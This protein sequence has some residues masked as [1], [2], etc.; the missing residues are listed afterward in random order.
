M[1]YLAVGDIHID[2]G[3]RLDDLKKVL[4]QIVSIVA[5]RKVDKVLFLGDMFTSRRPTALEYRTAYE[6]VMALRSAVSKT[7]SRAIVLLKGNHDLQRDAS[8]LD[9]F[10][11][12][13]VP[14][15][16]VVE[17]GHVEDGIFMGHFILKE[18]VMGPSNFQLDGAVTLEQLFTRF[19][20]HRLYLFGDIHTPQRV[21]AEPPV[22]YIGSVMRNNF[23]E[24]HNQPRV[25][26]FEDLDVDGI[27]SIELADRKMQQYEARAEGGKISY[28]PSILY[29]DIKDSIV[30]VVLS[31]DDSE[32]GTSYD[33]V[34]RNSFEGAKSLIVHHDIIR[35]TPVRDL[36]VNTE[37]DASSALTK[38]LTVKRTDIPVELVDA[39]VAEGQRI[40]KA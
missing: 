21:N 20:G 19:P 26:L 38:Y 22:Y 24:R 5:S 7:T 39:V 11:I 34:L 31:I 36:G 16:H 8:T 13:D 14:L 40:I 17:S 9:A 4:D 23:G 25:L 32:T 3:N 28:S 2:E 37:L 18:A 6:F 33:S 29:G 35:K 1:K 27:E 15:V 10:G 12:L 30:K